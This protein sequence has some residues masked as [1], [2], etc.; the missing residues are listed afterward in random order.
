MEPA[1]RLFAMCFATTLIFLAPG[2][3]TPATAPPD[4]TL[5]PTG[6]SYRDLVIGTGPALKV[7]QVCMV[8]VLGWIEEGGTKGR[9]LLDTRK[10]GYP[11]TFPFGVGRVI[12]GW[13]EGLTTMRV[14]G[15]R[16]LRVPAQLGYS[17]AEAGADVP[18]EATLL[19]EIELVGIR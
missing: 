3:R 15:K 9:L 18:A 14:G 2:C 5:T 16:L 7:G 12:K 19:F 10:R 1:V 13:D 6:L 8:E 11:D 17:P 4:M